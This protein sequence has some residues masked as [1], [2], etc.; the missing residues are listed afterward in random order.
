MIK[1]TPTPWK[2]SEFCKTDICANDEQ[3]TYIAVVGGEIINPQDEA[4][5]AHIVKCVNLHDELRGK[6][7]EAYAALEHD[8]AERQKA[9]PS[10]RR[11]ELLEEISAVLAKAKGDA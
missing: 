9:N 8:F 7:F 4:N 6:L 5:A 3:G 1:H 11:N 2:I 10:L